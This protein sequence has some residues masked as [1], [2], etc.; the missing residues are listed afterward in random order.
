MRDA[1]FQSNRWRPLA[2]AAACYVLLSL[3]ARG[4]EMMDAADL[5]ATIPGA[6][7]TGISN[8]DMTTRWVQTYGPGA[9]AGEATGDFGGRSYTSHWSVRRDLWC[10]EWSGRAGCW[11]L[12]RVDAQTIQ[13]YRGAEKLPNVWQITRPASGS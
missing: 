1:M 4:G 10:E 9:Q 7:L 6:T 8:E 11:R 5:L 3:P 12:E 2:A 13:P